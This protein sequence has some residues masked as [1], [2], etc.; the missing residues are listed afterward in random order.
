[1]CCCCPRPRAAKVSLLDPEDR[2]QSRYKVAR[3]VPL[4]R[5]SQ[6]TWE[7]ALLLAGSSL[8]GAPWYLT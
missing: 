7:V 1:M 8:P 6:L 5:I 4:A 3:S 2:C